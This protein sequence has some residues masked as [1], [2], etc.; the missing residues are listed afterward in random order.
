[1][2]K[3]SVFDKINNKSIVDTFKNVFQRRS[4]EVFQP[5]IPEFRTI[6]KY[7]LHCQYSVTLCAWRVPAF[8]NP[9]LMI[10]PSS[11]SK[12]ELYRKY[13][14]ACKESGQTIVSETY[15]RRTWTELCQ[16]LLF[17]NHAQT[18]VT[19]VRITSLLWHS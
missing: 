17:R 6:Q 8:N 11:C 16:M 4:S 2:I 10:L 14:S 12:A 1:M 3:M 13:Q 5:D 9:N 19:R 18:Y 15:F 7:M